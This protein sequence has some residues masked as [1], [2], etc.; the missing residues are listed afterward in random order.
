MPIVRQ[1]A[2]DNVPLIFSEGPMFIF[3]QW[4]L[5]IIIQ[6]EW[7]IL[8]IEDY[9]ILYKPPKGYMINVLENQWLSV[10]YEKGLSCKRRLAG[11]IGG[12]SCKRRLAGKWAKLTHSKCWIP[13]RT[14]QLPV[15][16]SQIY[17]LQS[18]WSNAVLYIYI[19]NV[20]RWC[21]SN[22]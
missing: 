15:F 6:I 22:S 11:E 17:H 4:K 5:I 1:V 8:L 10:T 3:L 12:L 2:L 7:L 21:V 16:K 20:Y 14:Q 18:G 13:R 19:S 9:G